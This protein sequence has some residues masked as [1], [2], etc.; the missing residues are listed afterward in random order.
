MKFKK[1][2]DIDLLKQNFKKNNL[3]IIENF[4]SKREVLI[5]KKVS[6]LQGAAMDTDVPVPVFRCDD[7]GNVNQGANPFETPKIETNE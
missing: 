1:M 5:L 6:K 3:L 2:L 7:C 4:F